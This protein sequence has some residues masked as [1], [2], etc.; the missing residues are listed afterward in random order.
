V[1][2]V[3]GHRLEM[4]QLE[5]RQIM[6]AFRNRDAQEVEQLIRT[7]NQNAL[8]AYNNYLQAAGYLDEDRDC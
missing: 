8:A 5:H 7:H 3:L 4:A 2:D 6:V 1:K